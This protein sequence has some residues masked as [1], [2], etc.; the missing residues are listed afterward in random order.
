MTRNRS[1][2]RLSAALAGIALVWAC[3]GDSPTA[4]P[5]PEPAR[6]STVTVSPTTARLTALGATVQLM[7]Q[8]RDQNAGMMAGATV[9][10]SSSDTSVATVDASGLVTGV[11]EGMATITASAGNASGSAVVSVMQPVATVEV[12][13]S[14]D[15]IGLGRTLQ[16]TAEGF[17]EN[18]DAVVG[19]AFSWESSDAAVATVDTSGLVTGVT[20]GAATITAS[21][22]SGQ[23]TVEITVMD[24]ERAALVALYNATDGPNWVNNENWLTDAPLGEWYGVDTDN[25]GRV[26]RL[27]LDGRWDSDA[28]EYIP[29]GLSGPV[30]PELGNL[31]N[32]TRLDLAHNFLSGPVPTE[33]GNLTDLESLHLGGNDLSGP[34]P[35]ELG[36]LANLTRL[37]LGHNFLS[38]PV[39]TE[40]GHLADLE[41]LHLGYNDLSGPVPTELGHLADLEFLHLGYNDLSGPIP[42]ELGHLTDLESLH[43]GGNDLSGPIPAELGELANLTW[44]SLSSNSL[45]GPVPPELGRLGDLESLTLRYNDLTGPIPESF[46]ELG[47]LERFHFERNADLCAPGTIDFVT[48]LEGIEDTSGPYCNESDVGVLN[49]LYE[50]S[51]GPDWTNS[52]G[53]FETPALDDWY[54]VT[55]DAIG[56]VVTLDLSR[57]GLA[58]QLPGNLSELAQM[59]ELRIAHNTDL[60]GRLPL[61]LADLSLGALHYAGTELCAPADAS[62]QAWLDDIVS[63]EGTSSECGPL[64]DREVL[65][66][67]YDVT[68]GPDWTHNENWRTDAPLG[69]W[70]GVEVDDQGRVV[71]LDF[72]RN[73]LTGRIP[74]ELGGLA[75]LRS[76]RLYRDDLTGPIPPELGHLS[77][78]S[79]LWLGDNNLSGPIPPELGNLANLRGLLLHSNQLTGPIPPEL[80]HL[81]QLS[82]LWLGDNNLSGPIPP[83]LG[84]LPDLKELYLYENQLSGPIPPQLGNLAHLDRLYLY[85]NQLSGPIP[86]QL[87]NLASVDT[88]SLNDNNLSGPIPP[89]L[90]H[91]S[92]LSR[93]WL[94]DNNLSGPI[95]PELG[96][97]STLDKLFLDTNALTGPVP[98]EFGGMTSLRELGLANNPG[99]A[100]ALPS[101]LMDLR[102]L[103]A[104]LAQG[105]ELC[106]PSDP[107]FQ[108]WLRGVHKRRII[109]CVQGDSPMAYLVQAVQSRAFPVPLVAEEKALLRVFPTARSATS[110]GIP[111]VRARFYIDGREMHVEDIPGKSTPIPT[112]VDEGSLSRS[113]NVEIPD[114]IMQPGLEMVVEVDPEGTLDETLGVAKRIPENGRIAVEV[115]TMPL[116]DLTLIPF[117][118]SETQDSSIVDLVRD[119]ASD[120]EN[121]EMFRDTRLLPIGPLE[122]T[123]HDPVLS[124]TLD[125]FAV[126]RQTDMIRAMEGGTGHYMG[127]KNESGGVAQRPGRSSVSGPDWDTFAHELGHNMN[128]AHAPCGGPAGTDPSF[129]YPDGN[130]GVWEY[131]FGGGSLVA[132]ATPDLMSYCGPPNGI[133]DYHFT[134]A[135]RYRLFDEGPPAAVAVAASTRS[136]LLWGGVGTE[137][138]PFLEP[139]FVVD[140][141]P[142]LPDSTGAYRLASQTADGRELF[143][144]TF[145]MPVVADGD[146]SSSFVFAL[147][148]QPGWTGNLATVTLSGPDGSTTLDSDTDLPMTILL[149]SSTGQV[150]GFL[151]N[152][153]QADA[154]ALA[155]QAGPTVST[156]SS[157]VGFPMPRR[158]VGKDSAASNSRG[159]LHRGFY[160]P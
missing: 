110:Q 95:P 126:L 107:G 42:P 32:L 26:V 105:T 134:N 144:F 146:G 43:L 45:T 115:R 98:P 75:D 46:V 158:G 139:A 136:L 60:S 97:L 40:L 73:R 36:N 63:H 138:E 72:I 44:L 78:L 33:L 68:G 34:V 103:E 117:V 116:F 23:G 59:T 143:S 106:A 83:E 137:G 61:S 154:A 141:P 91:L 133:S 65:Q 35:P 93:L 69:Q 16:L 13:P 4:P 39:P 53:W 31:A 145:A 51:G 160:A 62:F 76:L 85:E 149:D 12:S 120:P 77:Q 10:W 94:N 15:T 121:H 87:G 21:A 125:R 74:R 1:L 131:D 82:R 55:A 100:G 84:S 14:A 156:C 111:A 99:M 7:A 119:M 56:R 104:L 71:G 123:A 140:A 130:I 18:G 80:G 58:G 19:A 25:S 150:R 81:S 118:S 151:R 11:G 88:L 108:A 54:G 86:P 38:G 101:R 37:D 92:Q 9:T 112:E 96:N 50:T 124:S 152:L 29:H 6:P 67:L 28:R 57:N 102:Q 2:I 159:S 3:G 48:W 27:D 24:L 66:A 22:G 89:E 157:A 70:Y 147:P 135:L 148:V 132:P 90:G 109:S 8:V 17:D 5:T 129:P 30:P 64:S 155:P 128:L 142:A 79:R 41:F 20:V 122:V 114:D 113:A 153:S 47:A 52:S 127:L 49:L